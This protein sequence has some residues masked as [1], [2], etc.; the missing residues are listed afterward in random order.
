MTVLDLQTEVDRKAFAAL[1]DII[2]LVESGTVTPSNGRQMLAVL[3][4]AFNG[5]TSDKQFIELLTEADEN[6]T[7]FPTTIFEPLIR[8]FKTED[9]LETPEYIVRYKD[10]RLVICRHGR[11]VK[12]QDFE[13]PSECYKA[14]LKTH[15]FMTS[16][17]LHNL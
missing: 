11:V 15:K 9:E 4:T 12:R 17:G 6:L 5:V 8:Y 13:L 14:V 16:K 7:R 10:C 1:E 2:N 3:Q